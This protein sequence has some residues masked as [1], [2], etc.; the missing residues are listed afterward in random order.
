MVGSIN[1]V[2]SPDL[3][4]SI[5]LF[6]PFIPVAQVQ[7]YNVVPFQWRLPSFEWWKKLAQWLMERY[8]S[9]PVG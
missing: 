8:P 3:V 9:K 6:V 4:G 7:L 2:K 1:E 5:T